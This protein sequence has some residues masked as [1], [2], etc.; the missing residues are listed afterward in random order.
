M[1][2]VMVDT[3]VWV[4]YF[5]GGAETEHS[6]DAVDYLI[7][8]DEAIVDEVVLTELLPFMSVR[9]ESVALAA[10]SSI[11][12]PPMRMDWQA[13]RLMQEK[14]L[15]AGINKVGVPDLMIAQ[16][17]IQLDVPLFS[18]DRHFSLLST[19]TELK[20]WPAAGVYRS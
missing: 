1:Q 18:L 4:S 8:G 10:L 11:R 19:I 7:G 17:A 16:H 6:A 12:N 5:R 3:S 20:L 13:L 14:C 9:G 15:R 2:G